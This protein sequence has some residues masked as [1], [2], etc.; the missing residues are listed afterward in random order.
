MNS[1]VFCLREE[2]CAEIGYDVGKF[3]Q[4]II[5]AYC[6]NCYRNWV[7]DRMNDLETE[8]ESSDE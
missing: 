3:N 6:S 4:R 5:L 7:F 1:C 8:E 2:V